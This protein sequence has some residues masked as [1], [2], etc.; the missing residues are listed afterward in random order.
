VEAS[1][2]SLGDRETLKRFLVQVRTLLER[3]AADPHD[4]FKAELRPLVAA[5]WAE[6][7]AEQ[8]FESLARAI[9]SGEYEQ[10]MI[11]HGLGGAQLEFKVATF[12]QSLAAVRADERKRFFTKRRLR[13]SVPAAL[14]AADVTADSVAAVFPPAAAVTEFKKA[15]QAAIAKREV[16]KDFVRGLNPFRGGRQHAAELVRSTE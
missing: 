3:V 5:A 4:L 10:G 8:R 12:D 6:L 2:A 9:D 7:V 14:E 15:A 11:E 16:I 13:R 1:A